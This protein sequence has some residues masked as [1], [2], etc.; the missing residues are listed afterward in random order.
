MFGIIPEPKKPIDPD[1][2]WEIEH[3]DKTTEIVR[4]YQH[5]ED[6]DYLVRVLFQDGRCMKFH[7]KEFEISTKPITVH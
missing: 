2:F 4:A 1:Q 6:E 5:P 3:W 7:Y